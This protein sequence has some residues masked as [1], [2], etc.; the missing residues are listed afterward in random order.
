[1]DDPDPFEP[2]TFEFTGVIKIWGDS[3]GELVTDS[4]VTVLFGTQGIQAASAG[5]RIRIITR[6]FR[7]RYH[8]DQAF[9]AN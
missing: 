4:G 6:R 8:I 2:G 3:Y 7:P 5:S 1:M 9:T